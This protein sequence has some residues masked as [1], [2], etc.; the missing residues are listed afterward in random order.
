MYVRIPIYNSKDTSSRSITQKFEK[1]DALYLY[2]VYTDEA[3]ST[4]VFYYLVH[5]YTKDPAFFRFKLPI[6]DQFYQ[7]IH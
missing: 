3:M 4:P 5:F 1:H 7:V 2:L 6:E